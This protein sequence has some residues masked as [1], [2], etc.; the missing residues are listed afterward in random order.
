MGD[1]PHESIL[2]PLRHIRQDIREKKIDIR[3][4]RQESHMA[5]HDVINR[6]RSDILR[7][8]PR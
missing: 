5:I 4:E 3:R 8:S 1:V 6:L 2:E 7:R